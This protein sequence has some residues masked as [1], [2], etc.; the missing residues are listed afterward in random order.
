MPIRSNAKYDIV[1]GGVGLMLTR[2]PAGGRAWRRSGQADNPERR[3]ERDAQY[4]QLPAW[5]DKSEVIN[6]WSGGYG[7]AYR[8]PGSNRYH[9][10]ENFDARWPRQLI[11]CQE[12]VLLPSFANFASCNGRVEHIIDMPEYSGIGGGYSVSSARPRASGLASVFLLGDGFVARAEPLTSRWQ[13]LAVATS[14][15]YKYTGRPAVFGSLAWLG[16]YDGSAIDAYHLDNNTVATGPIG[17]VNGHNLVV[18]GAGLWRTFGEKG[19]H[20]AYVAMTARRNLANV[21]EDKNHVWSAASWTASLTIGDGQHPITDITALDDQVFV[22][23]TDGLYAGDASGTFYNVLPDIRATPDS[24]NCRDLAT[25]QGA[26]IAQHLG[27]VSAYYPSNDTAVIRD[28]G[29]A[30]RRSSQSPIAGYIRTLKSYGPWLYGGLFTGSQGILMAG[31][32]ASPGLPFVWH[33]M[34]RLPHRVSPHRIHVDSMTIS[35]SSSVGSLLRVS[36]RMW[37]ATDASFPTTGTAPLYVIPIPRQNGDPLADLAFSA[38]YV[39]SARMDMGQSEFGAPAQPKAWRELEVW[40]D[41]LATG[42][43]YGD[44]YYTIDDGARTYLGRAQSSPKSTLYFPSITGSIA[45]GQ[46]LEISLESFTHSLNTTPVWRA[47]V[48]HGAVLGDSADVIEAHVNLM[49]QRD[50]LGGEMPS[51]SRLA[52]HLDAV[53]LSTRAPVALIDPAGVERVVKVQPNVE[54]YETRSPGES[55]LELVRV[56]RMAALNFGTTDKNYAEWNDAKRHQTITLSNGNLTA[57]GSSDQTT[58]GAVLATIGKSSGKWYWE[59]TVSISIGQAHG[60]STTGEALDAG[61]GFANL[62]GKRV[63]YSQTG[64]AYLPDTAY[65][66]SY[67]AGDRLGFALDMDAGTLTAYRNGVSQ[68]VLVSGLSGVFYPYSIVSSVNP[69]TPA[70]ITANFGQTAFVYA[71]PAGFNPGLYE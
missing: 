65:G 2:S 6:D 58:N 13:K 12:P 56:L 31:I 63:Y 20:N 43:L 7:D 24:D 55:D 71:V 66:A 67:G 8:E 64:N 33:T 14:P 27:G 29:P 22:G 46:Q 42:A 23:T 40:A 44:F 26:V 49:A 37:V 28:I 30:N 15:H 57:I 4:G 3:S 1:V 47:I 69:G 34:Q 70:Q 59:I 38:A 11:H 51:A 36:Q 19:S 48:L 10:S 54:E 39:G 9:W 62:S 18:A 32:D 53:A 50:R 35:A 68:G 25:H 16:R 60:A 61:V 17:A 45:L 5:I 52:A 41:N 21:T